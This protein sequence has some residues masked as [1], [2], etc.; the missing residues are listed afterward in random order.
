MTETELPQGHPAFKDLQS[1]LVSVHL[2]QKHPWGSWGREPLSE[3]EA[4]QKKPHSEV[5]S[6]VIVKAVVR[7]EVFPQA[8]PCSFSSPMSSFASC[9]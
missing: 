2:T 3:N 8:P 9:F 1:V 4:L 6:I 5:P 7:D